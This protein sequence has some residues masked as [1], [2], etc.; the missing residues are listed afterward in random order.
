[1]LLSVADPHLGRRLRDKITPVYF[2]LGLKGRL[3][4]LYFPLW[5]Q[6][7]LQPDVK[8]SG[9]YRVATNN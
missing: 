6:L 3:G 2:R 4:L 9:P 7:K 5:C 1:M 8:G